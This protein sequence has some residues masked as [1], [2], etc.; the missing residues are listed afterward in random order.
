MDECN[1]PSPCW[2]CG[3][4]AGSE[5]AMIHVKRR[6][7]KANIVI[8]RAVSVAAKPAR[9]RASQFRAWE[10]W[11]ALARGCWVLQRRHL[12]AV[13]MLH[14]HTGGVGSW[15][16]KFAFTSRSVPLQSQG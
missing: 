1:G 9:V 16:W 6:G 10:G 2:K 15:G 8:L 3:F 12:S 13:R 4:E 11:R 14:S 7:V 5:P